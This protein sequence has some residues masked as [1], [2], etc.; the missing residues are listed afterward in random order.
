[1]TFYGIKLWY[2]IS[3]FLKNLRI[4]FIWYS[5]FNLVCIEIVLLLTLKYLAND[6]VL[7]KLVKQYCY[8]WLIIPLIK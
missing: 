4:L 7:V 5:I 1:M 2:T 6:F 3:L 8:V